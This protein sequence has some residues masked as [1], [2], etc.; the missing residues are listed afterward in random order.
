MRQVAGNAETE[1]ATPLRLLQ[2]NPNPFGVT[3]DVCLILE[4]AGAV[5]LT[6]VDMSGRIIVS[7]PNALSLQAGCHRFRISMANA[8][9]Y[10]L[11]A[12]QNGKISSVKMMCNMGGKTNKI[13][14]QD[15]TP[16]Q[17]EV[18]L[19]EFRHGEFINFGDNSCSM[20]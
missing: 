18:S 6:V 17:N 15:V 19:T 20:V 16:L 7:T 14:Y 9:T 1:H 11:I 13:E 10:L 8:G 3:T 5:M 4:E 2:N 12:R